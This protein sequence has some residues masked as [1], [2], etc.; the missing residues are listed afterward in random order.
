MEDTRDPVAGFMVF[1]AI[2]IAAL[3]LILE[4]VS[5]FLGG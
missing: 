1:L 2:G 4:M 3:S 5:M